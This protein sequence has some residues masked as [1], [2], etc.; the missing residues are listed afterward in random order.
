MNLRLVLERMTTTGDSWSFTDS[1]GGDNEVYENLIWNEENETQKPT[2]EQCQ[3]KWNQM[4]IDEPLEALRQHR[5]SLLSECDWVVIRAYS[6]GVEVPTEWANYM[7]ALRDL[8]ANVTA[9]LDSN[10]LNITNM[11]IFPTKPDLI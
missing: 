7:Q 5:N 9:V 10:L 11:E 1:T 2:L 3:N 6:Q 8:P 4:L